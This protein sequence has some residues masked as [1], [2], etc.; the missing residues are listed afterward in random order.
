MDLSNAKVGDKFIAEF[1]ITSYASNNNL[2][3]KLVEDNSDS[4][5]HLSVFHR[6]RKVLSYRSI[7]QVGVKFCT[8]PLEGYSNRSI[9][10]IEA[11]KGDKVIYSYKF[12][13]NLCSG[14]CELSIV[15]KYLDEFGAQ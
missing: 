13:D 9:C 5:A 7:P 6:S 10:E 4:G 14:I 2:N 8:V 1:I 12:N 15:Q 3:V 11:I